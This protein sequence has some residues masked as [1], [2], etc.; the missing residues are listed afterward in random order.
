MGGDLTRLRQIILNLLA[1]ACKFTTDGE[2][3]IEVARERQGAGDVIRFTVRD[4]GIGM[5][6]EQMSKLFQEFSQADSSTTRRF[7]G[8]GLGLALS[9]RLCQAMGGDIALVSEPG[10]GTTATVRL[11][12]HQDGAPAAQPKPQTAP[13]PRDARSGG[14]V[15][16]VDDDETV[17][18]LMHRFLSREGFAVVTAADGEQA[19]ELARQVRPSLITLD[20]LMP[21]LDGWGVLKA[22]KAEP[23]LAPIPVIM[24]S[25]LDE[26]NKGYSLGAAEY[27][28]KPFSRDELRPLLER[29]RPG[30]EIRR[31]LIVEDQADARLWMT[32]LM[33][34]E[35]WQ[36]S[37]AE[38]GLVALERL[39]VEVPDLILLD[40]M[41]PEMDGF[42][43][44]TALHTDERWRGV[45]VIVLTAADLTKEDRARLNGAVE[46]I[47]AKS[48]TSRDELLTELRDLAARYAQ[49]Q[50]ANRSEPP[51]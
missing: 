35:G 45:P 19:L 36:V 48:A 18:D 14:T 51:A 49:D 34:S 5:T 12:A 15:L 37:E 31:V 2:V 3:A 22:L 41:M 11:P 50:A 24:L 25:I 29:Y 4:T 39:A 6:S 26:K 38:N 17:R 33:K 1:N 43:L 9:R 8:T 28:T 10:Q 44:A 7:G 27:L 32:R 42:E 21:G 16:V 46:R 23:V 40:L 47:L 30:G 13:V 20:V